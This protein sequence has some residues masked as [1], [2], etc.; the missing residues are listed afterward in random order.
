MATTAFEILSLEEA[1]RQL[2]I[3]DNDS[4]DVQ[5]RLAIQNA[6]HY[7]SIMT[8]LPLIVK[9]TIYPAC[10][11]IDEES[12]IILQF[13]FLKPQ[14]SD[15]KGISGIY[16]WG[17]T[18]KKRDEP[19]GTID[20]NNLGYIRNFNGLPVEVYPPGDGWPDVLQGTEFIFTINEEY[21][22]K[23][24]GDTVKQ[25]VILMT[26]Q[27]YENPQNFEASLAVNAIL[28]SLKQTPA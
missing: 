27:F 4:Q 14:D 15:P 8:G 3:D 5:T 16:Y 11:P 28:T 22:L 18:Q 12:P 7:V 13:G 17:S 2:W 26:R 9:Q 25:V 19:T 23:D 20:V 21:S 6:V 24:Q 1:K 10:P